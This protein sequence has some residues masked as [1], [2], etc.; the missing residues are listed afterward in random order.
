VDHVVLA[1]N[2][3]ADVMEREMS[4]HAERY[5]ALGPSRRFVI[6][7]F[8]LNVKCHDSGYALL[9]IRVLRPV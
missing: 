9:D 2:Y 8:A 1:V 3:R 7:Y 6:K 5:V 4:S